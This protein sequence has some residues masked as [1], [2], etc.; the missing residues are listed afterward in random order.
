MRIKS[1]LKLVGTT[2]SPIVIFYAV[3]VAISLVLALNAFIY[4]ELILG[5]DMDPFI[6]RVAPWVFRAAQIVCLPIFLHMWIK[7][8]KRILLPADK[9]NILRLGT[10]LLVFAFSIM[11]TFGVASI[12]IALGLASIPPS[13]EMEIQ[14]R[15][16]ILFFIVILSSVVEELVFR[17]IIL[18]RLLLNTS[19]RLSVL[20]S[21]ILF[22]LAYIFRGDLFLLIYIALFGVWC[23]LIYIRYRNLLLCI[24]ARIIL[25]FIAANF[26]I[27]T[28]I[29][30]TATSYPV[31]SIVQPI[32]AM[33][34]IGALLVLKCPPA[35]L[36][37]KRLGESAVTKID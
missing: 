28:F 9:S 10:T 20:I 16:Y 4:L 1:F 30:S 8:R 31:L 23:A 24:L 14:S 25:N 35:V 22:A 27:A 19:K 37:E 15:L 33:L 5:E 36:E 3:Y 11:F 6:D 13:Y 26:T 29:Y 7:T 12:Y 21:S 34:G 2:L 32:A 18:N 17:G